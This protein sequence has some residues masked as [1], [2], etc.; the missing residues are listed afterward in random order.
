METTLKIV[1]HLQRSE[2]LASSQHGFVPRRSCLTNLLTAEER[3]TTLMDTGED[4]DLVYLD[5]AKAF[6]S[7][8]HRMLLDKMLMYGIHHSIVDWTRAFL[9]NRSYQTLFQPSVA[10][11]KAPSSAP[12]SF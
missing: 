1:G 9:S 6:D 7:V 4:V 8:N 10:S 11:R 2:T 12:S 5:F 3:N